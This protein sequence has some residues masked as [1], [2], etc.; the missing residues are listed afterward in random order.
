MTT[1]RF[2]QDTTSGYSDTEL[3]LANARLAQWDA[4]HA[5]EIDTANYFDARKT[6]CERILLDIEREA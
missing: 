6:A 4:E 1:T 5:G 2:E 3:E